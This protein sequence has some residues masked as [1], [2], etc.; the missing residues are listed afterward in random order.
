MQDRIERYSKIRRWLG[1]PLE[2]SPSPDEI[3]NQML[4][5]EQ[6]MMNRLTNTGQ[7]WSLLSVNLYAQS[8]KSDYLI[9]SLDGEPGKV[10][11]VYRITNNEN[12]PFISIE[13]DNFN[14]IQSGYIPSGVNQRLTSPERISFY[15]KY[16]QTQEI[17]AVIQPVP[18]ETLTY[19]V[20]F[21][22]GQIDRLSAT[23]DQPAILSEHSD[24][25][26]LKASL[27][28][29]PYTCWRADTTVENQRY[30]SERRREIANGLV[31]QLSTHERVLD[32]YIENI[33]DPVSFEMG[34]WNE[35]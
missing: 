30:N 5:E 33:D 24:F 29:L 26:D 14:E 4:V 31:M 8:G 34:H 3:L 6:L 12:L 15:R 27:A 11:F 20:F 23:L 35:N 2:Q 17:R 19:K 22:T 18:R 28:L 1:R 13:F 9:S 32:K 25:L 7:P 10:Y 16:G 21:H